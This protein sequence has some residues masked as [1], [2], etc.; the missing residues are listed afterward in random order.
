MPETWRTHRARIAGLSR[1]REPDDPELVEARRALTAS[2]R[3]ER[4]RRAI[5]GEPALTAEQCARLAVELE[6]ALVA[7]QGGAV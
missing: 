3:E 4:V 6:N 2:L 1:D 5:A 7:A